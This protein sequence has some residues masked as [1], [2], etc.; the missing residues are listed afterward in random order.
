MDRIL[1]TGAG[2]VGAQVINQLTTKHGVE[3]VVLDLSFDWTYLDTVVPRNSFVPIEGS[4]LDQDLI[5][6]II[7][8]Y[9][10]K[11]VLHTAAVLPMRVGHAAHPA[12]YQV[13][14]W[15]TANL[16]FSSC[17]AGV[18]R[19]V[20]FSTNGVYQFKD[21]KVTNPVSE[22]FPSGLTENNSYGNSKSVAEYLVR[23]MTSEGRIDAAILRPGEIYGP[24]M[25]TSG[26]T[27]IYWKGMLDAAI[28]KK[29]LL[30]TNHPE[31]RLD[32]VYAKDVAAMAVQLLRADSLPHIEYNVSYG[33]IM[34]IYEWKTSLDKL[35]PQNHIRLVD[36]A[37]GGWNYPLDMTRAQ[38][39][40]GFT[41][42]YN[43]EQ[44][45]LDYKEWYI[46][47]NNPH[48]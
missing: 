7:K 43:L 12:F 47:H 35:F 17:S 40:L 19:F 22:T 4:I 15:G 2:M 9:R 5:V 31:H 41:P 13:N 29:E 6:K 30:L 33:K 44:G 48:Q 32:W 38:E 3:P 45:I 39:D 14:S 1:I 21:H 16:L 24:V 34:G 27:P 42:Q 46:S 20:M 26:D 10:I 11:E 28:T 18:N 25:E 8:K 23:E 36:C 37:R